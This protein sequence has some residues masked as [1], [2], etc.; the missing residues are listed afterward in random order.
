MFN[1]KIWEINRKTISLLKNKCN[2][3]HV[4]SIFG[5]VKKVF[6]SLKNTN[7]WDIFFNPFFKG[8]LNTH[9]IH[10]LC[11]LLK[12]LP[13]ALKKIAKTLPSLSGLRSFNWGVTKCPQTVFWFKGKSKCNFESN[14]NPNSMNFFSIFILLTQRIIFKILNLFERTQFLI[15]TL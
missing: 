7:T 9:N 2:F 12:L 4:Q 6:L 10:M 11:S 3:F 15:F 5:K 1:P 13:C 14:F 8:F